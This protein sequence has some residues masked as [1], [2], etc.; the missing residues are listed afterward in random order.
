MPKWG[1]GGIS[2]RPLISIS[3]S[4]GF[5]VRT[6]KA[7]ICA[8]IPILYMQ[9]GS[10]SLTHSIYVVCMR[11]SALYAWTQPA[12]YAIVSHSLFVLFHSIQKR[13]TNT[14]KPPTERR[15]IPKTPSSGWNCDKRPSG[16]A[17]A[18]GDLPEHRGRIPMR[19]GAAPATGAV[20]ARWLHLPERWVNQTDRVRR[21]GPTH[22]NQP[23]RRDSYLKNT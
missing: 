11:M 4:H 3:R 7:R 2:F 5:C 17:E 19:A 15:A 14:H 20:F 21:T 9:T 1:Y 13:K 18:G 8:N 16:Y 6:R 22:D 12:V 10:L 23:T